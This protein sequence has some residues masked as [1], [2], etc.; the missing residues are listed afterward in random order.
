MVGCCLGNICCRFS[1]V[2]RL[3]RW[4]LRGR[5]RR[6]APEV[7]GQDLTVDLWMKPAG[8]ASLAA[9]GEGG[10]RR[11][12]GSCFF[13]KGIMTIKKNPICKGQE[14]KLKPPQRENDDN[15]C[16]LDT[17]KGPILWFSGQIY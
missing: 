1:N 15:G 5:G 10:A 6:D 4:R 17:F 7:K 9:A 8:D 16:V 3:S 11:G 12:Q 13:L 2:M 14:H